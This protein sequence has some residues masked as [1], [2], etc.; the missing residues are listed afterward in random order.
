MVPE[1][2]L[3]PQMVNLFKSRYGKKV[4]V[5]HSGL[6]SGE[7]LDEY[8]RVKK[9]EANIVI[10]TRS[11][12]F[13]P[14]KDLALIVVDEEHET[15]YKS[16]QNPRYSAKEIAKFRCFQNNGLLVVSS[17]TPSIED[18]YLAK[19]GKFQF[20]KL[21]STDIINRLKFIIVLLNCQK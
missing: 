12:V 3:T 1:I 9:H 18:F 16:E 8:K 19:K 4:A 5:F 10:G 15:T 20:N 7:R 13:A 6:F 17:A 11:A 14:V 21:S 2:A